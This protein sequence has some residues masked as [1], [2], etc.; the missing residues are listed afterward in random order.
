MKLPRGIY[1]RSGILYIRFQDERG[2]IC[3]EST[4]QSSI[5]VAQDILSK[6]K[7]EVAQGMYFATRRF[8]KVLFSELENNWWKGH[9]QYTRSCFRYLRDRITCEFGSLRARDVEVPTIRTFFAELERR[10]YSPAYINS[11]RTMLNSIFNYAIKNR[12]YDRN[13]VE[14]IPQF[15]ERERTRLLALEEW[16]RL[17]AACNGNPELRCFVIIAAVTTM[18]KSE[19]LQRPWREVHLDGGFPYIEIPITKNDDSKIIPLPG[20]AVQEMKALPSFGKSEYL[21]PGVPTHY[22][23][24]ASKFKKPHRWD[25]KDAFAKA[26]K[27]AGLKDLHIHDLRHLGPSI[28]L[29]QGVPDSVVAKVTG[30]R[31]AALKRYQ[32]LSESF[33]KQ[34]VDLIASVLSVPFSDT[35]SD[36]ATFEHQGSTPKDGCKLKKPKRMNGRPVGT[37]TPDLYRVKVAL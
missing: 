17:L 22:R 32:H 33:R 36:T 8:E 24:D 34:T 6:R 16:Q 15:R 12:E 37:R 13:P 21:F 9:G 35:R 25:I 4:H 10:E 14:S 7:T 30:H 27:K 19:I 20:V 31:S 11:H 29:A 5:K 1:E 28:L 2:N 3:R 18:R 23:P 26:R